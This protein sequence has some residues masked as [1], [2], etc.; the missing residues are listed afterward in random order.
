MI[1]VIMARPLRIELA[2]G[3]FHITSRG[4]G[5]E[6]IFLSDEDRLAW[7][8]VLASVCQRFKWVCHAWCLMNN[9]YHLLIETPQPNLAR[10]MRQL[11]GVYTQN[12][13]RLHQRVGHVF[14]GRYKAI[15][16]EQSTYLLEL[17]R[18]IVLNPIRAGMVKLPEEWPWSSYLATCLRVPAPA[19]H[20]RDTVLA[21]F[22]PERDQAVARYIE[23]VHEGIGQRSVW[24]QLRGQIY[25][26]PE[27]FIKRMQA[28]NSQ[29]P[30]YSAMLEI[31]KAQKQPLIQPIAEFAQSQNR[32]KAIAQAY[33]SGQHTMAAIAKY[34][35][36]HY[37][38][39]SRIVRKHEQSGSL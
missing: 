10:G 19:W 17:S 20:H 18:Y 11:N 39:V 14:Q 27:D 38:T 9:H 32:N 7:L 34:F 25:L 22:G 31:P 13:N 1:G 30:Q 3:L 16:V 29:N 12:F 33:L 15:F 37:A 21:L 6:D 24:E 8:S 23:F 36:L 4:D 5:R 26:G 35:N 28:N 2:G